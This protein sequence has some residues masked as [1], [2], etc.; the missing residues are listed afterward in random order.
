MQDFQ[1]ADQTVGSS[2]PLKLLRLIDGA[3]LSRNASDAVDRG[4]SLHGDQFNI[5]R[6]AF[7][8][9][10]LFRLGKSK[11]KSQ[12]LHQREAEWLQKNEKQT[13]EV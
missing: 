3:L 6:S 8:Q 13:L 12:R 2:F 7:N 4:S 10:H 5:I 9:E 1:G 11:G